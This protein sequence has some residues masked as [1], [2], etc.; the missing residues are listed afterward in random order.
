M[1]EEQIPPQEEEKLPLYKDWVGLSSQVIRTSYN[2]ETKEMLVQ[3]KTGRYKYLAVPQDI[4]NKSLFTDSIGRF[5]NN[6][7]KGKY[8]YIK[9]TN[10]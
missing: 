5:I 8:E 9:L 6:S 1:T 10:L 2:P 3:Y 4:W 7:I